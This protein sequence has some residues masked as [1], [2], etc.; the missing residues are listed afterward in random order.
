MKKNSPEYIC[1]AELSLGILNKFMSPRKDIDIE[2]FANAFVEEGYLDEDN[3]KVMIMLF[4]KGIKGV[5]IIWKGKLKDLVTFIFLVD[6][7]NC[8]RI[9]LTDNKEV[10]EDTSIFYAM[11]L[12]EH[13]ECNSL[14]KDNFRFINKDMFN[15]SSVYRNWRFV[16]NALHEC[17]K[18]YSEANNVKKLPVKT[19]LYTALFDYSDKNPSYKYGKYNDPEKAKI[20]LKMLEIFCKLTSK[21]KNNILNHAT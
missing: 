17:I 3:A 8:L 9:P 15:R 11:G 14:I 2:E 6:L 12:E 21:P 20:S 7:F 13:C 16:D 18:L 19:F 4:T 5:K 10:H 1:E